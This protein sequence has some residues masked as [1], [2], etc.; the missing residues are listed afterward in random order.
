MTNSYQINAGFAVAKA[1]KAVVSWAEALEQQ[2]AVG[3]LE[4]I[5]FCESSL[6]ACEAN[7]EAV[8]RDVRDNWTAYL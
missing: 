8:R 3:N 1:K 4:G 5:R 7:L 6:K 2:K